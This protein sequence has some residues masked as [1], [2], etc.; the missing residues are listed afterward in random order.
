M[1]KLIIKRLLITLP[2]LLGL[3]LI[4]FTMLYF[5]PGDPARIILGDTASEEEVQALREKMGLNEPFLHQYVSYLR[6]VLRGDLGTSYQTGLPVTA[7]IRARLPV[8]ARLALLSIGFAMVVG[9]PLGVVSAVKQNTW[10]DNLA[11]I[12]SL[13]GL[14]MPSFWLALLLVLFFAVRLGWLPPSGMYGPQ[15]YILPVISISTVSIATFARMTRSSLLETVR[16]D[17]VRTARAK[18]LAE[19]VVVL[20]HALRNAL[21]PITTVVG[22]QLASVLGG[23]VVNEQIFAI[24]GVGKMMLDAIK[25]RNYPLVQGGVLVLAL[26]FSLL[27]LGL[28]ILYGLLD[29]RIRD[30][31]ENQAGG[32]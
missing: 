19:K 10:I 11:R 5:S 29:P 12:L 6:G 25:A 24:P 7:E 32:Y 2:M 28:D 27:N 22:M 4:V 23:A 21:I 8:T 30:E 14:T 17:Y 20:R 13:L 1:H 31:I 15:Y 26:F 9:I 3:T 16:H 18:G